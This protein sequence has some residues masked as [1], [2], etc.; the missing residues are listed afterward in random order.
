MISLRDAI[1]AARNEY[2]AK[3]CRISENDKAYIIQCAYDDGELAIGVPSLRI[4]KQTGNVTA[5]TQ[6][7]PEFFSP[8]RKIPF[9]KGFGD[10]FV[11]PKSY[12]Q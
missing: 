11:I 5:F 4:D 8:L 2:H 1:V 12:D 3:I 10:I 9:P 7:H 6:T